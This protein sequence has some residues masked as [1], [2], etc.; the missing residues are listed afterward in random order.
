M[1]LLASESRGKKNLP[2]IFWKKRQLTFG[3]IWLVYFFSQKWINCLI[4]WTVWDLN[5]NSSPATVKKK[6]QNPQNKSF[7]YILDEAYFT[8]EHLWSQKC[9]SLRFILGDFLKWN[10]MIWL[11]EFDFV[12]WRELR[13][14]FSFSLA[15][16]QHKLPLRKQ[17]NIPSFG[18]VNMQSWYFRHHLS[19]LSRSDSGPILISLWY[20]SENEYWITWDFI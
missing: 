17:Q 7:K 6:S 11:N 1:Q 5:N 9:T 19:D 15:A 13:R 4:F 8:W 3:T 14:F 18:S 10:R 16:K 20:Q 2:H 12:G